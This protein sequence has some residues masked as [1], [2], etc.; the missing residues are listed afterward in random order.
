MRAVFLEYAWPLNTCER[1]LKYPHVLRARQEQDSHR[2]ALLTGR[3]VDD[4]RERI[5]FASIEPG[6]K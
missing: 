6:E 4:I 1:G 2:L 3:G 5:N